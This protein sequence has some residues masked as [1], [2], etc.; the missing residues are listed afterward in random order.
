[1]TS[2]RGFLADALPA[3]AVVGALPG[4]RSL[5]ENAAEPAEPWLKGLRGKHKQFF[6]VNAINGGAP[7]GRVANFYDAY[8]EAYG[9]KDADLNAIFGAHGD[10]LAFVLSDALWER[11]ELG[12]RYKVTDPKTGQPARR[13]VF[14]VSDAAFNRGVSVASLMGRGARFLG[15]RQTMGRLAREL[16]AA[17]FGTEA[18]LRAE[19]EKGL[20][21]GATAV[22]AMVVAANRA[23][24]EGVAYLFVG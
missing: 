20:V 21:S 5:H 8:G 23:Q 1:M 15:C 12:A 22:P 17:K 18:E 19:I 13:N 2:R 3:M 10:G 16:A 11:F 6:D 24:E 9:L 4:M 7:L 14:A